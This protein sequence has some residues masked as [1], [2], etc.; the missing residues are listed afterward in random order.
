MR[1]F[2][3]AF[4]LL[5]CS[6]IPAHAQDAAQP[7]P[8]EKVGPGVRPP[9]ALVSPVAQMPEQARRSRTSGICIINLVVDIKGNPENARIDQCS[10][11]M[12]EQN[13]MDTVLRYRFKPAYRISDGTPVPV[14][15]SIETT[16]RIA[17]SP[18]PS[19]PRIRLAFLPPSGTTSAGPDA[20][21]VYPLSNALE[22]PTLQEFVGRGFGRAA[23]EF[24]D[25]AGCHVLL[26]LDADGKPMDAQVEGCSQPSLKE[27]AENALMSSQYR[28]AK[29]NG[30]PVPVRAE[31]R[32]VYGDAGAGNDGAAADARSSQP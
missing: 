6:L 19:L 16:F 12:F 26:T 8:I 24:P 4:L 5:A 23:R 3:I 30:K 28:P 25:G 18:L 22:R 21:G 11:P 15:I 14:R 17:G 20:N 27:L 29:L 9:I 1:N 32:L 7:Q 10:D 31:V 13:S 2:F